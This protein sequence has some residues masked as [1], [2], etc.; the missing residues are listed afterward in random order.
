[1]CLQNEN[2]CVS[3]RGQVTTEKNIKL[4]IYRLTKLCFDKNNFSFILIYT[5]KRSKNN[6]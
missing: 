6:Y 3:L 4:A 5:F 1:M 2:N